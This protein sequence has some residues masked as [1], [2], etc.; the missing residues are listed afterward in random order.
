VI[1]LVATVAL[2]LTI[3]FIQKLNPFIA[4]LLAVVPIKIVGTALMS[5]ESGGRE[6]LMLSIKGMLV[7]Q[8]AWGLAL[9]IV[10]YVLLRR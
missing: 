1:S 2:L 10:Y 9:A 6:S 7:G 5:V 8:F 3:Y 4:G